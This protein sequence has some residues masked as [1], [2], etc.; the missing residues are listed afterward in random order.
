[1]HINLL[2]CWCREGGSNPHDRKGRRILSPL[3]LPVPPSRPGV[4]FSVKSIAQPFHRT[5]PRSSPIRHE[6][7]AVAMPSGHSSSSSSTRK[8][9]SAGATVAAILRA[10]PGAGFAL[11][12]N[13]QGRIAAAGTLLGFL[14]RFRR[15]E[16]SAVQSAA[17]RPWSKTKVNVPQE[18]APARSMRGGFYLHPTD[19][20]LSVGIPERKKPLGVLLPGYSHSGLAVAR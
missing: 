1:M 4:A 3:R 2:F 8:R 13:V 12:T 14:S 10:E 5:P 20:D 15:V 18:R 16:A 7:G 9:G 6:T 11:Q 17:A 19:E